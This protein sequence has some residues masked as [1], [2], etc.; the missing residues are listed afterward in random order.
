MKKVEPISVS[1]VLEAM[2]NELNTYNSPRAEVI[3]LEANIEFILNELFRLHFDTDVLR[4]IPIDK[5]LDVLSDVGYISEKF[6]KDIRKIIDIRDLYAHSPDL[7]DKAIQTKIISELDKLSL[8]KELPENLLTE[9]KKKDAHSQIVDMCIK[10]LSK[11]MK[12]YNAIL[13]TKLKKDD[14]QR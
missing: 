6:K 4:R 14:Y 13:E 11:V 2:L 1:L 10:I 8:I 5:K 7:Y 3:I 9:L 12:E